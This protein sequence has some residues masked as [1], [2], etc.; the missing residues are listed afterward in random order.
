MTVRMTSIPS[1]VASETSTPKSK[2]TQGCNNVALAATSPITTTTPITDN[3]TLG[4]ASGAGEQ[5]SRDAAVAKS[6]WSHE[7]QTENENTNGNGHRNGDTNEIAST[8]DGESG[9]DWH[10]AAPYP[11]M[12]YTYTYSSCLCAVHRSLREHVRSAK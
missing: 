3:R 5:Y 4:H 11:G 6:N 8:N 2:E 9:G 7:G 10:D 1:A 12:H